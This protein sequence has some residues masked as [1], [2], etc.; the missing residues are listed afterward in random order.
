MKNPVSQHGGSGIENGQEDTVRNGSTRQ[1]STGRAGPVHAHGVSFFSRAADHLH[2]AV[3]LSGLSER[4][5][6]LGLADRVAHGH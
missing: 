2:D 6:V 5:G 1:H 4:H 3:L